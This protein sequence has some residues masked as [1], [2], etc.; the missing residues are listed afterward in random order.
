MT[1]NAAGLP[2]T[3]YLFATRVKIVAGRW[4]AE[5]D[6][7]VAKGQIARLP[8][9]RAAHLAAVA[10]TR[11]KRYLQRQQLFE[12]GEATVAV[13]TEIVHRSPRGWYAEIEQLLEL[14]QT[15]GAEKLER[16][17]RAAAQAGTFTVAFIAQCLGTSCTRVS[18]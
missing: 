15:L 4:Q 3:L 16:A 1:P 6:R 5:H 14:M 8:E 9:H 12:C 13:L 10:G 7:F 18:A 11:G 2:A 17:C